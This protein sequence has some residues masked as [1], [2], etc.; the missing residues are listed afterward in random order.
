MELIAQ[1]PSMAALLLEVLR[2][3]MAERA[4][5][6]PVFV[7]KNKLEGEDNERSQVSSRPVRP[8]RAGRRMED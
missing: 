3:R 5:E 4:N 6:V 7:S 1:E 2:T 8:Q